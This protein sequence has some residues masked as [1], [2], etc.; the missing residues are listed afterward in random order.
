MPKFLDLGPK[1]GLS[2]SAQADLTPPPV[3]AGK[4]GAQAPPPDGMVPLLQPKGTLS[5]QGPGPHRAGGC[6]LEPFTDRAASWNVCE[7]RQTGQPLPAGEGAQKAE[8]PALTRV[9]E[10]SGEKNIN[11]FTGS[12]EAWKERIPGLQ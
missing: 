1:C 10:L 8:L 7:H 4:E 12:K 6:L 3:E 2:S 11:I 5:G 9:L